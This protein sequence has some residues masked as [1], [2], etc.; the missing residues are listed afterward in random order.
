[1][2]DGRSLKILKVESLK[3]ETNEF[4]FHPSGKFLFVALGGG[5]LGIYKYIFDCIDNPS[6]MLKQQQVK[7]KNLSDVGQKMSSQGE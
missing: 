3:E 5:Q 6:E 1:M 7:I 4:A 2:V